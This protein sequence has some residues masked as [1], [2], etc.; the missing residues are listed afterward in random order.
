MKIFW[1]R[2]ERLILKCLRRHG[3]YEIYIYIVPSRRSL[4]CLLTLSLLEL[5]YN[6]YGNHLKGFCILVE[7]YKEPACT[8]RGEPFVRVCIC[9]SAQRKQIIYTCGMDTG[10]VWHVEVGISSALSEWKVILTTQNGL[11]PP[12]NLVWNDWNVNEVQKM[13]CYRWVWKVDRSWGLVFLP[14]GVK[15]S[16][17]LKMERAIF[18]ILTF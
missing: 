9:E 7:L 15:F 11:R 10:S 5:Q 1:K 13:I 8:K 3:W 17:F 12:S 2:H 16:P 14:Y 4:I 18:L 6:L